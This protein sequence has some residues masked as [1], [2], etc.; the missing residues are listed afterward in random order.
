M[1]ITEV[2]W[3]ECILWDGPLKGGYAI[4][5]R[6]GKQERMARVIMA[7]L[8]GGPIPPGMIVRHRCDTPTCV[9]PDHLLLG[10]H[11]DNTADRVRRKRNVLSGVGLIN[12]TK[13]H[14]P[15]GHPYIGENCGIDKLGNRYCRA[16]KN[17]RVRKYRKENLDKINACRKAS[18]KKYRETSRDKI[19]AR[20]RAARER[21]KGDL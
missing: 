17:A 18:D 9:T 5:C 15:Q 14:C 2:D 21:S 8:I 3:N 13:T 20:R 12:K 11:A 16:C 1:S 6:N 7:E 10:T 4:R 19:N